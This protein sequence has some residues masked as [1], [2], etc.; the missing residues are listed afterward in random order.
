VQLYHPGWDH[1]GQLPAEMATLTREID[2]PCAA[3]IQDLKERDMLKD[4]LVIWGTEF[5]RTCYSQGSI[6]KE[7]KGLV[8]GREHHKSCCVFWMAGAGVKPGHSHGE[9]CELGF[10]IASD[11]VHV[12]DLHATVL[13]LLGIDHLR[14][15][16]PFRG[17]DF[18]L[19][20]V[21]GEVVKGI[22]A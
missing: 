8:Y 21:A 5:G 11:P 12:N 4:T 3:L 14:L 20:D 6:L 1:H 13:H 17:R 7:E 10:D 22:L 9:T 19:T 18:R 16:F 15:T 2:Q